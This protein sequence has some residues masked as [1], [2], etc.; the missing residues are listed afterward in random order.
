MRL[1]HVSIGTKGG[2]CWFYPRVPE[3]RLC[4]EDDT[5]KRI[6]FSD[7][8]ERALSAIPDIYKAQSF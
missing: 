1:Y 5:T 2:K 7:S 6:C 3:Y 8:I 4:G